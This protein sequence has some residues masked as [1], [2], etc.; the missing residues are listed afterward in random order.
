MSLRGLGDGSARGDRGGDRC[1]LL[2]AR[3]GRPPALRP[4]Q[5][6]NLPPA[7]SGR[8]AKVTFQTPLRDPRTHRIAS[9][10]PSGRLEAAPDAS[11]GGADSG[12]G[13]ARKEN[14][15]F[16]KEVDAK[17]TNGIL[18]QPAVADGDLP[19]G[20][21]RPDSEDRQL[22]GPPAAA[23]D[24]LGSPLAPGGLESQVTY[25]GPT[26][27]CPG[28]ALAGRACLSTEKSVVSTSDACEPPTL[29]PQEDSPGAEGESA[30]GA[31]AFSAGAVTLAGAGPKAIS[32]ERPLTRPPGGVPSSLDDTVADSLEPGRAASPSPQEGVDSGQAVACLRSG[33]VQLEL[34]LS[35]A[36]AVQRPPPPGALQK[37]PS[38]RPPSTRPEARP[39]EPQSPAP[40]AQGP[41]RLDSL[42]LDPFGGGGDTQPPEHP[43]SSPA[44]PTAP[45]DVPPSRQVPAAPEQGA[46]DG[47][48]P[49]GTAGLKGEEGTPPSPRAQTPPRGPGLQSQPPCDLSEE[50]FRDPAE[51]LG[52]GAEVDY[53]EQ[54]GASSF[55]ASALRKHSLYLKFDPLLK[56]S[57]QRPAPPGPSSAPGSDAPTPGS[58]LATLVDLDFGSPA[59]LVPVLPP[60]CALGPIVDLLQYSQKDLDAAVEAARRESLLL[61]S[62][63]EELQARNLEMGK[64]MEGF[65]GIVYQAVEEAQK[66][67]EHSK[68]EIQK[69]LKEKEQ[70]AADL[71]SMEKS[72]SELFKR[73]EKQKEAIEGY[74]TNEASLK[75]CVEDSIARI[76]EEGQRYRALKAHAEEKLRLANEEIAQVRSKAH[77]E[78]SAFQAS[79]RREQ[80]RV[81]SLEKTVEQKT[82]ENEELTR[83][84]DDLIS[85]MERI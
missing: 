36:A 20:D 64:I 31:S 62:R 85:K 63:C 40:P 1:D 29:V 26:S 35:D 83:I 49:A 78:A 76:Q 18:Q 21:V 60:P 8:A 42:N 79:L 84:C 13:P 16:A 50:H 55:K 53:L 45:E 39:G 71:S 70:L 74:R 80:M 27:G 77:A 12:P 57:P 59:A 61:K 6:E 82:K 22:C 30:P 38:L 33:P 58:P 65:E 14:Q 54:F 66:Q 37:W 4:S 46:V 75:K 73:F 5:K 47:Q 67:K 10:Q 56:E 23:A 28:Q 7:G 9:P 3:P 34:D 48:T 2:P 19:L 24:P 25:P 69:V 32:G 81:H 72:F 52:T 44:R 43:T 15:Q 17:A 68:A 51:A 11:A 41:N